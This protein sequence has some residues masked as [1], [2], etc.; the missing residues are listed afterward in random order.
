AA[1]RDLDTAEHYLEQAL[2]QA[3]Q[4]PE[5]LAGAGRV[6]RAAGKTRKAERYFEAALAARARN[7]GEGLPGSGSMLAGA[8]PLGN[9]FAGLNGRHSRSNALRGERFAEPAGFAGQ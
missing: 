7:A 3:P 4:S 5:V 2:A 9:P 6:Y 1:A 8:G